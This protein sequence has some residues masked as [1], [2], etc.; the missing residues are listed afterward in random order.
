MRIAKLLVYAC[1]CLL[2]NSTSFAE[3]AN[4]HAKLISQAQ[5]Y[6][7]SHLQLA[8]DETADVRII[9]SSLPNPFPSCAEPLQFGVAQ[10]ANTV[11]P[12]SVQISCGQPSW[13]MFMPL[14]VEI[15]ANVLV[16]KRTLAAK[17]TIS[18]DDVELKPYNKNRLY[19][20]YFTRP[21]EVNGAIASRLTLAGTIIT[22]QGIRQPTLI[23][24]NQ[25]V[26]IVAKRNGIEV[27]MRGVA[28]NDGAVHE[29]IK[30]Y[31]PASKRIVDAIVN[32]AGEA[33]VIA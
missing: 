3:E 4:P 1:L 17:E 7:L 8:A 2:I 22:R 10:D 21:E 32:N 15:F 11:Q 27:S 6:I 26:R 19:Q 24:R 14:E 23:H 9:T 33:E 13:K 30:I 20:G 16:A 31:N 28:K 5:N 29:M 25:V 18:F 12:N